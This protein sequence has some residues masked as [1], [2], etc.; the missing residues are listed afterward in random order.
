MAHIKKVKTF[1]GLR[2]AVVEQHTSTIVVREKAKSEDAKDTKKVI[3]KTEDLVVEYKTG[4]GV[5]EKIV[6][7]LFP[8]TDEGLAQAREI[9]ALFNKKGKK[10]KK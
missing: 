6:P 2:Y 3:S 4:T 8:V 1:Y 9:Q 5:N 7:A 10:N